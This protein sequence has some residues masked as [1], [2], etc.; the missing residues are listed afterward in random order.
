MENIKET[1]IASRALREKPLPPPLP[2]KIEEWTRFMVSERTINDLVED[3]VRAIMHSDK[4][5][6]YRG[7]MF[8]VYDEQAVEGSQAADNIEAARM[9]REQASES[10]SHELARQKLATIVKAH[11]VVLKR[12]HASRK[13]RRQMVDGQVVPTNDGTE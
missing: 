4:A 12:Y 9:I 11:N 1:G 2:A 7:Y 13:E 8:A 5:D 6:Q 3:A 10:E